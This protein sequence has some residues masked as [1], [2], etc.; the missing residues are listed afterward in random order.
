MLGGGGVNRVGGGGAW[1]VGGGFFLS[2]NVFIFW[3]GRR[4]IG[5]RQSKIERLR[6]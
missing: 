5:V 2:R 3:E 1:D 6:S 4:G